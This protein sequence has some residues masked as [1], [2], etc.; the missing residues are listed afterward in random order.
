MLDE[1]EHA[2]QR[3]RALPGL[4]R[5]PLPGARQVRRRG[6]RRAP[7]ARARERDAACATPA[8]WRCDTNEAGTRRHRGASSSARARGRPTAP[9]SSSSPAGR[10]TRPKLLLASANEQPPE[11]A[12][13]RLRPG[14]AQ[15]HVPQQRRR[16][17]ALQGGEPDR[18]PEDARAQRLLLRAATTSSSR[19]ATSRWWASPRQP[20][21]RGEKPIETLL[22]PNCTL[23]DIARH[24]VDFWLSTEDL[25]QRGEPRH[26]R[27]RRAGQAQLQRDQ[28]RAAR[29]ALPQ[30]QALAAGPPR[31][32]RPTT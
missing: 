15:L 21:Y 24:A 27:L 7:G 28:R 8:P 3:V 2:L 16:A 23:D 18:L 31:H 12:G 30:A 25:P 20:M 11:R 14:G 13:Q 4:R 6:D 5:L 29:T 10:P 9:T 17:R 19:W 22:A 26:A 1:D 32:A